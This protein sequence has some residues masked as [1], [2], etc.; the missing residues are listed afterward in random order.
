M[1]QQDK[2]RVRFSDRNS[3]CILDRRIDNN[4]EPMEPASRTARVD[5]RK[6]VREDAYRLIPKG[7]GK[8]LIDTFEDALDDCQENINAFVVWVPDSDNARGLERYMSQPHK[9]ERDGAR[10]D[11]LEAVLSRQRQLQKE[12]VVGNERAD[13]VRIASRR[14]SWDSK[15]FARRLGIADELAV[16]EEDQEDQQVESSSNRF[17]LPQQRHSFHGV[18]NAEKALRQPSDRQLG[19]G[20]RSMAASSSMN[21]KKACRQ[22]SIRNLSNIRIMESSMHNRSSSG[23][24]GSYS[25]SSTAESCPAA[26]HPSRIISRNDRNRDQAM[27]LPGRS[28]RASECVELIQTALDLVSDSTTRDEQESR[29]NRSNKTGQAA[30]SA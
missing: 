13:E 3:I 4:D 6:A 16:R 7:Y 15:I 25:S 22:A 28:S 20:I 27:Q 2:R 21:A 14:Q 10:E 9:D 24:L 26:I 5:P 17:L 30:L 11:V 12:E 23:S 18:S 8:L 29:D 1:D 19:V